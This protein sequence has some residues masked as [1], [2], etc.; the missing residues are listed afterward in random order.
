MSVADKVTLITGAAGQL[1]QVVAREFARQGAKLALV[2]RQSDRLKE[3][4]NEI[5]QALLIGEIDITRPDSVDT[6]AQKVIDELGRID[7]LLNLAGGWRG[8]QP[9][10][11]VDPQSWDF[12]MNLNAK[13]VFLV[14]RAVI[15]HMMKQ[16]AGKI[17][18]VA[19][20]SG[21][22]G[23]A[24]TSIYNAS[25]AVVIRLT[26]SMAAELRDKGINVNCVL[27][28]IIDTPQNREQ[29]PNADFTR[30]VSPKQMTDVLL[31]LASDEASAL[32]GVALTVNGRV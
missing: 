27:P 31:Y 5:D 4:Y 6:M 2:D 7:I 1:G 28:S 15:P 8:G 14:C 23:K 13:S 24:N 25:K 21:L 18:S 16:G 20:K 19:A 12:V 10:H 32:N 29:T 17:I 22:E 30:W 3:M 11:E 9:L 26:E